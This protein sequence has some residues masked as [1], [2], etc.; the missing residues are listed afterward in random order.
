MCSAIYIESLNILNEWARGSTCRGVGNLPT[1]GVSAAPPLGVA[2]VN[3]FGTGVVLP[4]T[5]VLEIKKVNNSGD[6]PKNFNPFS[7]E[8][9]LEKMQ[10]ALFFT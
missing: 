8:C 10:S 1:L 3:N 6:R 2:R 4:A 5:A 9:L 7:F